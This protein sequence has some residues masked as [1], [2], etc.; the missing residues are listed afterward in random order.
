MERQDKGNGFKV[1][2]GKQH[3]EL[4]RKGVTSQDILFHLLCT[5]SHFQANQEPSSGHRAVPQRGTAWISVGIT[6]RNDCTATPGSEQPNPHSALA[7]LPHQKFSG[8]GTGDRD[9]NGTGG[10]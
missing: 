10:V 6:Q 4:S 8:Q 1:T 5:V 7:S 2:E 3:Q 9:R